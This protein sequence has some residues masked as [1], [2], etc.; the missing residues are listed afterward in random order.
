MKKLL[1]AML[2]IILIFAFPMHSF[3]EEAPTLESIANNIIEITADNSNENPTT[4]YN[5]I[6][7][8]VNEVRNQ[9]PNINDLELANF[10]MDYAGQDDLEVAD[11]EVLKYLDFKE[12]IVSEDYV[13]V[14]E[15]GNSESMTQAGYCHKQVSLGNIGVNASAG[16]ISFSASGIVS[17]K[18][19]I[20]GK[21]TTTAFK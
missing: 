12:I 5:N 19:Y 11:E 4:T 20:A 18:D 3:A 15:M 17:K 10:I 8:F 7:E 16:G 1:S 6:E 9:I 2:V 21:I 14:D 13:K